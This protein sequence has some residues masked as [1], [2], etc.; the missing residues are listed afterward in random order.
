[1]VGRTIL[2]GGGNYDYQL[3]YGGATTSAEGSPTLAKPRT[4]AP[5]WWASDEE[6]RRPLYVDIYLNVEQGS[7]YLDFWTKGGTVH[8]FGRR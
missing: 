1:M 7:Y 2:R 3:Y 4:G 6:P 8:S 5:L